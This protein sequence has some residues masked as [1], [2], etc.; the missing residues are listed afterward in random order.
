MLNKIKTALALLVV[1]TY[2]VVA[3]PTAIE[4]LL[5]NH[6]TLQGLSSSDEYS[7]QNFKLTRV[8]LDTINTIVNYN[9]YEN[10]EE[11]GAR[12]A[13]DE[14]IS[15]GVFEFIV[16]AYTKA[17]EV[18]FAQKSL[19]DVYREKDYFTEIIENLQYTSPDNVDEDDDEEQK[20]NNEHLSLL[21]VLT[22]KLT[23]GKQLSG[24]FFLQHT[25]IAVADGRLF[26]QTKED[27][28]LV[29]EWIESIKGEE[30]YKNKITD[31]RKKYGNKFDLKRL[32]YD[33]VGQEENTVRE[34][35]FVVHHMDDDNNT[36]NSISFYPPYRLSEDVKGRVLNSI[37][38]EK[39][40]D[41]EKEMVVDIYN[42]EPR[43]MYSLI[44]SLK[45]EN[46]TK[47]S[48]TEL[49][50]DFDGIGKIFEGDT[51][52]IN[53]KIA[54]LPTLTSIIKPGYQSKITLD[55]KYFS[56]DLWDDLGGNIFIKDG[57]LKINSPSSSF[58]FPAPFLNAG[59]YLA[60]ELE[61]NIDRIFN[62]NSD[63][64][65]SFDTKFFAKWPE[66]LHTLRLKVQ[67]DRHH[68]FYKAV[69]DILDHVYSEHL[70]NFKLIL[71]KNNYEQFIN[72]RD[73]KGK[74]KRYIDPKRGYYE[75]GFFDVDGL[76]ISLATKDTARTPF[77]PFKVKEV[78]YPHDPAEIHIELYPDDFIL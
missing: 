4:Q 10:R 32:Y 18:L 62:F 19:Y 70:T 75:A 30:F 28:E 53:G 33:N 13:T 20:N 48:F 45:E 63:D 41:A 55:L 27:Q 66:G 14:E 56:G 37:N 22:D 7:D 40:K 29:Q 11:Y 52:I 46:S 36:V 35:H 17:F 71:D 15:E 54:S 1:Q 60:R 64:L 8:A 38:D 69:Y 67:S 58:G 2:V 25:Q 24:N 73:D 44:Q 16:L 65:P 49:T 68:L 43:L 57:K 3:A 23:A 12:D 6:E 72:V 76:K 21:T 26:D 47:S 61:I 78:R 50:V 51:Q 77:S 5:L 59:K 42:Y 39:Y 34:N 9:A 74:H 31:L